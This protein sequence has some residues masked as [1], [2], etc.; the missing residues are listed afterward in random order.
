M[1]AWEPTIQAI[2]VLSD[3]LDASAYEIIDA[4]QNASLVSDEEA[5]VLKRLAG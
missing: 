5:G 2:E 1:K 4:L 3:E